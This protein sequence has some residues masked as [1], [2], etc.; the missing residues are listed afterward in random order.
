MWKPTA[1]TGLR[2]VRQSSAEPGRTGSSGR[3]KSIYWLTPDGLLSILL[4]PAKWGTGG[5][6]CSVRF[7]DNRIACDGPNA[8]PSHPEAGPVI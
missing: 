2:V 5:Y 7:F 3:K 6:D 4:S 8:I 1:E